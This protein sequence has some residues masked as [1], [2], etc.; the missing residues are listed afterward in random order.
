MW[1]R[2]RGG[3]WCG[4]NGYMVGYTVWYD[5]ENH[6]ICTIITTP[7]I[8]N[9]NCMSKCISQDMG[10]GSKECEWVAKKRE[11]RKIL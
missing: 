3:G 7:S 4:V 8:V 10:K 11:G 6:D 1:Q 5:I 9:F 2:E